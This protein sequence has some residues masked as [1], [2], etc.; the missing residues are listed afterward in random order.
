MG[1]RLSVEDVVGVAAKTLASIDV[2]TASVFVDAKWLNVMTVVRLS[3]DSPAGVSNHVSDTFRRHG[4]IRTPEFRIDQKVMGF[5]E[6]DALLAEFRKGELEFPGAQWSSVALLE[7][8]ARWGTCRV[9]TIPYG[10]CLSGRY[11][12]HRYPQYPR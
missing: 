9:S 8:V 7:S 6:W 3:P 10:L 2:R 5:Q 12:K 11:L 1:V 4:S